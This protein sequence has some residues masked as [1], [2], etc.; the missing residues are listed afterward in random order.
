MKILPMDLMGM[1]PKT[2]KS[3]QV[4]LKLTGLFLRAKKGL[5]TI[6]ACYPD[7][8]GWSGHTTSQT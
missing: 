8:L 1:N 6:G 7:L 2:P 3:R 4:D 5:K